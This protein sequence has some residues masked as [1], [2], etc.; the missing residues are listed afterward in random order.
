[1]KRSKIIMFATLL[2]AIG[3][4]E[5]V[6][7][8]TQSG[9]IGSKKSKESGTD[10]YEVTCSNA[11]DGTGEPDHLYVNVKD[12]SPKNPAQVSIQA[13]LSKTAGAATPISIDATDGDRYPSPGY[14]LTGGA[15]PYLMI[16]NKSSSQV[17]GA[18]LYS[19]ELHCYSAAGEHTGTNSPVMK[20][21]Q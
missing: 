20:K 11:G 5:L 12:L 10:I 4:G 6:A 8:H 18:E 2:L 1:M 17:A 9:S 21:N 7:A 16:V 3:Y 19:V 13:V 15:G 14:T